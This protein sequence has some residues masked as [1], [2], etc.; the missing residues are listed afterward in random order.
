MKIN[1]KTPYQ[2]EVV[3]NDHD[4]PN[5]VVLVETSGSISN[6]KEFDAEEAHDSDGEN[7]TLHRVAL[8]EVEAAAHT[9]GENVI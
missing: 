5:V 7:D 8:V 1:A 2:S 4:I 9:H 6:D 3:L